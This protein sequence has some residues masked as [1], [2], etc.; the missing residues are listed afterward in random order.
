MSVEVQKLTDENIIEA[1]LFTMGNS[2]ELRQLA[3]AIESDET[4]AKSAVERLKKRYEEEDRAMQIIELESSYQMCT[5]AKYY[6]SLI[7]V[8]KA[9]KK[10]VLTDAVLETLSI[11]AYR[12]PVTK[13]QID[14]IRG[15]ASD[16]ALNKLLEYGLVNEAARLDAPGRQVL[17]ATT[18][19]FLRRFGVVSV[20]ELPNLG[21]DEEANIL[22]EVEK[23]L[24]YREKDKSDKEDEEDI[25]E[26]G[27]L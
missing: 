20:S 11:V 9:P 21:P 22:R 26:F 18:E 12:Q 6:E 2:V 23:E 8:A 5:K 4:N 27:A 24:A 25:V 10:Q 16:Y 1:I 13:S 19:E 3:L 17:F 7:R 14:H 15:V